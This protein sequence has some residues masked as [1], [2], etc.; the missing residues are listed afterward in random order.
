M[1]PEDAGVT[2]WFTKE[3]LWWRTVAS[4]VCFWITSPVLLLILSAS[5]SFSLAHP[6]TFVAGVVSQ[7]TKLSFW[8]CC[9]LCSLLFTLVGQW[10]MY[11]V[12]VEKEVHSSPLVAVVRLFHPVHRLG[13]HLVYGA[14][15][16]CIGA[17]STL[18]SVSS[19]CAPIAQWY[20]PCN[21][22]QGM[23]MSGDFVAFCVNSAI[24][25]VLY[26]L[27]SLADMEHCL[28]FPSF[29]QGRYFRVR[30]SLVTCLRKAVIQAFKITLFCFFFY[31][32]CGNALLEYIR[33]MLGLTWINASSGPFGLW[34]FS[35]SWHF[36]FTTVFLLFCH[37]LVLQLF[38]VFNSQPVSFVVQSSLTAD[39]DRLLSSALKSKHAILQYLAYQDFAQVASDSSRRAPVFSLSASGQA[40]IWQS[41]S[42]ECLLLINTLTSVLQNATLGQGD[43]AEKS[44]DEKAA[45]PTHGSSGTLPQTPAGKTAFVSKPGW[46]AMSPLPNTD[47]MVRRPVNVGAEMW[48]KSPV[49]RG[50]ETVSPPPPAAP[51]ANPIPTPAENFTT[52]IGNVV[53]ILTGFVNYLQSLVSTA[54]VPNKDASTTSSEMALRVSY[55]GSQKHI[56]A[57]QGLCALVIA[58]YQEDRYGVVQ[59][60]FCDILN[61]LLDLLRAVEST[62]PN[63][64][65]FTAPSGGVGI[66]IQPPARTFYGSV[67]PLQLSLVSALQT[68]IYQI[69]C[70]FREHLHNFTLTAD[71]QQRLTP[72]LQYWE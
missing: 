49:S 69:T 11:M 46:P 57:V 33:W 14:V 30:A 17:L 50:A 37:R 25:G 19:S 64:P 35:S 24:V 10:H 58:S 72:F 8:G 18:L 5:V 61:S 60:S 21:G 66:N 36:F 1:T 53:T 55:A 48:S 39:N 13:R 68:G 52:N 56:W 41:L 23:C 45:S 67:H 2:S 28:A 16:F 12:S 43:K 26:S 54:A 32:V 6:L 63:R 47:T 20:A 70:T 31:V 29:S 42:Q 22:S 71:N 27:S 15:S 65:S 59:K 51:V 7:L 4:L 38:L 9:L 44:K 62:M 34:S 40:A 3:V